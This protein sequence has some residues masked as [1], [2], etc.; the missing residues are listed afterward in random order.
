MPFR[1][2]HRYLRTL[3]CLKIFRDAHMAFDM[4]G[5][6]VQERTKRL[7]NLRNMVREVMAERMSTVHGEVTVYRDSTKCVSQ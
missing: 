1:F 6:T 5:L 7:A 3:A 2:A 4:P